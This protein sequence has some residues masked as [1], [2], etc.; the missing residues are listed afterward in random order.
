MA[1]DDPEILSERLERARH[2]Q[3]WRESPERKSAVRTGQA[4]AGVISVVVVI[5]GVVAY[6]LAFGIERC[7]GGFYSSVEACNQARDQA[8]LQQALLIMGFALL[9]G[10]LLYA[11]FLWLLLIYKRRA[12]RDRAVIAEAERSLREAESD[13]G[14]E[15]EA[16]TSLDLSALWNVT[17]RRLDYYHQ[18][19]TRQAETSFRNGQIAMVTGFVILAASLLLALIPKSVAASVVTGVLGTGA[20][21]LGAFISWTFLRSQENAANQLRGYFLQPL[22]FS[23][24]LV[25][26]RLLDSLSDDKKA[27]G[28]LTIIGRIAQNPNDEN[29]RNKE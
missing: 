15:L 26:E 2:R 3:Q 12:F 19:A 11:Y 16:T 27:E 25:A 10:V 13:I 23:R 18:I 14:R 8:R 22:E 7:G 5:A 21:A 1:T 20:G 29:L 4:A 24:Y 28:I 9:L 17:H 6:S